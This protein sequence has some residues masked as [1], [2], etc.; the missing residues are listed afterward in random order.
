MFLFFKRYVNDI[1]T[2]IPKDQV[3]KFLK[4]FNSYQE[5]SLQ[6]TIEIEK[7]QEISFLDMKLIRADNKLKTDWY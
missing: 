6:F 7:H 5:K 1:C 3:D 2:C 4:I